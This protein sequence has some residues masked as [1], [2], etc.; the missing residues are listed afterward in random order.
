MCDIRLVSSEDVIFERVSRN[1]KRP[2]LQTENPRET[3]SNLLGVRRPIYEAAA[4]CI[5]DTTHFTHKQS[6]DAVISA[7]RQAFAWKSAP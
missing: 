4:E 3:L 2:L 1:T 7:A 5:I 6:A